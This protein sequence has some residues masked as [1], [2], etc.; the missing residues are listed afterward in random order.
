MDVKCCVINENRINN[1]KDTLKLQQLNTLQKKRCNTIA[2]NE[3]IV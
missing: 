2:Y 3:F 1:G